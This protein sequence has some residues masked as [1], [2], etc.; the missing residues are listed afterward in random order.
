MKGG[1]GGPGVKRRKRRVES[2]LE[3]NELWR[4]EHNGGMGTKNQQIRRRF[5]ERAME[6]RRE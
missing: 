6:S 4:G 5:P 2:D 1:D 3:I